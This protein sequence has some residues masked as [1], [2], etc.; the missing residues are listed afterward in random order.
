VDNLVL[1]L[2]LEQT[3]ARREST[4]D[5]LVAWKKHYIFQ[6]VMLVHIRLTYQIR[7]FLAFW[8]SRRQCSFG[9]HKMLVIINLTL[10]INKV[11]QCKSFL[12]LFFWV[13]YECAKKHSVHAL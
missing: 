2:E 1:F 6:L 8:L 3:I 10:C 5:G 13:L 9:V 7:M 11:F 12:V 4:K